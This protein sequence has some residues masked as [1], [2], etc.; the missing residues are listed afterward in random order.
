MNKKI[1][2]VTKIRGLSIILLI[3]RS[4]FSLSQASAAAYIRVIFLTDLV[5]QH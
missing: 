4:L 5:Y 1:L 3:A 2:F